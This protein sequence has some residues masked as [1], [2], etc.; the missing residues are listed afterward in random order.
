[1]AA[2]NSTA[3]RSDHDSTVRA[4]SSRWHQ[5]YGNA[6][7]IARRTSSHGRKLERLGLLSLPR[8]ARILD[9]CCGMGEALRILHGAGFTRLSGCD[10][11]AEPELAR[12]PWVDV[13][14]CDAAS[15]PYEDASFDAV[16]CMH[17]LHHL[18][19]LERIRRT[20][21]ECARV[22]RPGGKLS[23]LDHYN[24]PQLR[25]AFW[26]LSK[27]WLTWPTAG[28]RS[29]REQHEEEWPYMYE[30]LDSWLGVRAAVASLPFAP[31]VDRKGLFF[32]YWTG[33]KE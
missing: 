11:T 6:Q 27:P 24:S 17:S 31:E 4:E 33:R 10:V 22:L 9:V 5:S 16:V 30:Y 12:E 32:F 21:A 1:M 26:G 28:L 14:A 29:F 25:A 18:G 3:Q 20:F 19:G 15:L 13:R 7:L 2:D 23:L 8:D